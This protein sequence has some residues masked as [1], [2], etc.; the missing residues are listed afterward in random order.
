MQQACLDVLQPL[1]ATQG[2]NNAELPFYLWE[3]PGCT[4]TRYPAEGQF[5]NWEQYLEPGFINLGK[6]RSL[7]IP[8]QA[9]LQMF[10]PTDGYYSVDGPAIIADTTAY[11]SLWG[12]YNN[13]PCFETDSDCGKQIVWNIADTP[14]AIARMRVLRPVSWNGELHFRALAKIPL[15]LDQFTLPINN[16]ELFNTLCRPGQ[17]RWQCECHNAFQELLRDHLVAY[18]QSFVNLMNNACNSATDYVPSNALQGIGSPYQCAQMIRAQLEAGTFPTLDRG[19]EATYVCDGQSY[20]NANSDGTVPAPPTTDDV[21]E[22]ARELAEVAPMWSGV[23]TAGYWVLGSLLLFAGL[24]WFSYVLTRRQWPTRPRTRST[25]R[26]SR[27]TQI[28]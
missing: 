25:R 5:P 12:H 13:T 15:Q 1:L 23:P 20:V 24:L 10:A 21:D 16:D 7:F 17:T 9:S 19:G 27:P 8:H 14:A 18:R 6:I 11:L 2:A 3:Y 28:T 4:G 26:T 22:A